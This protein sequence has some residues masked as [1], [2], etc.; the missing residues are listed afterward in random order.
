MA[1]KLH[2][3]V[4]SHRILFLGRRQ[5]FCQGHYNR[6]S[7]SLKS[8]VT[9]QHLQKTNYREIIDQTLLVKYHS[10]ASHRAGNEEL[11]RAALN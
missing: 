7:E 10:G 6:G 5:L 4:K 2:A 3:A 9:R 11:D 1:K 8:K